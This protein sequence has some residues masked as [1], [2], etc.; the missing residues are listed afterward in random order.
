MRPNR[1]NEDKWEVLSQVG[2]LWPK[3]IATMNPYCSEELLFPICSSQ[4]D[5]TAS[6]FI[7]NLMANPNI[8]KAREK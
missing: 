3:N 1:V 6:D 2:N 7:T 5:A 4:A 8:G